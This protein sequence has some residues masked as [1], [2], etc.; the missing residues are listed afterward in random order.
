MKKLAALQGAVPPVVMFAIA[1]VLAIVVTE[2]LA[3]ASLDKNRF[4]KRLLK[5]YVGDLGQDA[6]V[7]SIYVLVSVVIAAIIL[8]IGIASPSQVHGRVVLALVASSIGVNIAVS[9]HALLSFTDTQAVQTNDAATSERERRRRFFYLA[10]AG[11]M[12]VVGFMIPAVHPS[13]AKTDG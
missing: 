7:L 10:A 8:L 13:S 1:M 11:T 2:A 4:M 5:K 9:A 6:A 3:S 12:G